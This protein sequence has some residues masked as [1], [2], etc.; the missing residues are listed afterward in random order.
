MAHTSGF[1]YQVQN[2][3]VSAEETSKS[4]DRNLLGLEV[5]W[6]GCTRPAAGHGSM[7]THL[8]TWLKDPIP[9][10]IFLQSTLLHACNHS[11]SK[12]SKQQQKPPEYLTLEIDPLVLESAVCMIKK[13]KDCSLNDPAGKGYFWSM[14]YFYFCSAVSHEA[15]WQRPV[16]QS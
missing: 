10:F 5:T 11:K 16:L 3:W 12:A 4:C 1:L 6:L 8:H 15:W 2:L 14:I 9:G 13:K 7:N